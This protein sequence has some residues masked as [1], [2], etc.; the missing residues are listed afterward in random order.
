[1]KTGLVLSVS[2]LASVSLLVFAG[3]KKA[4]TKGFQK[5][6]PQARS[7]DSN[8]EP[9]KHSHGGKKKGKKKGAKRDQ[10][11]PKPAAPANPPAKPAATTNGGSPASRTC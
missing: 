8:V 1:M 4:D 5:D 6:N 2:L 7:A 9:G 10:E 3:C 11:K